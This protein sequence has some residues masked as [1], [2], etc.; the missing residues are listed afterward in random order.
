[1]SPTAASTRL[2][3]VGVFVL[4][5]LLLFAVA[6]FM[7]GDRQMAFARKF[8]IYTQFA[9]ITGLAPGAI[10]RVA[11]AKAGEVKA[12]LPPDRPT[13]KFKVKLEITEDLHPLVRTDSVATIETEGLVGGAFL[14]VSTGSEQAPPA[15]EH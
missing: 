3:G 2:A 7:I 8:T 9:K 12:I 13:D 5:G 4:A 1:M 15:P 14:G 10:V 6:L 11:G